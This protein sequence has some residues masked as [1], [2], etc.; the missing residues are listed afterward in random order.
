MAEDDMFCDPSH[1]IPSS[2]PD[3]YPRMRG[4]HLSATL[5]SWLRCSE[6]S[7]ETESEALLCVPALPFTGCVA[8]WFGAKTIAFLDLHFPI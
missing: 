1:P 2:F 6:W 5:P 3:A 4:A 8:L 7:P